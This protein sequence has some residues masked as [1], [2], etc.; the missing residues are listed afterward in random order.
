MST[1][2]V[3]RGHWRVGAL[4]IGFCSWS[5][6]AILW[7]F[8]LGSGWRNPYLL[9]FAVHCVLAA[10]LA[11]LGWIKGKNWLAVVALAAFCS[12]PL[13]GMLLRPWWPPA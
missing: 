2:Q 5:V 3:A 11:G 12:F 8:N 1:E 9:S 10:I 7:C 4:A 6:I 13:L